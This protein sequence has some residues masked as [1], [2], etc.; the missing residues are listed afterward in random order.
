M[1][2]TVDE[3]A[4][5]LNAMRVENENNVENFEKALT[6]IS[7]KLELMADDNEATDLIKVY[8]TELKKIVDDRF[9]SANE[10]LDVLENDSKLSEENEF[11]LS[12]K[13]YK[14]ADE[15]LAK[16]IEKTGFLNYEVLLDDDGDVGCKIY[17]VMR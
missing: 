5:M 8:L 6:D 9:V 2:L 17:K 7:T 15:I 11:I 14:G 3:I 4:E 12:I 10:K 13:K 16:V 1:A